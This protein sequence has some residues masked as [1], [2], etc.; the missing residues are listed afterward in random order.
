[1]ENIVFK[2]RQ[3]CVVNIRFTGDVSKIHEAIEAIRT[4]EHVLDVTL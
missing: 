2:D 4:N 1:M 3:A